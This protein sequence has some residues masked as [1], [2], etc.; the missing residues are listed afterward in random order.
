[1]LECVHSN[2]NKYHGFHYKE[3]LASKKRTARI[4]YRRTVYWSVSAQSNSTCRTKCCTHQPYRGFS[5]TRS[6]E[7]IFSH[8]H[9]HTLTHTSRPQSV[10]KRKNQNC[11]TKRKGIF[12]I[13]RQKIDLCPAPR[14]PPRQLAVTIILQGKKVDFLRPIPLYV[15]IV[16]VVK[17]WIMRSNARSTLSTAK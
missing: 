6:R 4:S 7:R 15:L 10:V 8:A 16:V 2:W 12:L 11:I 9:T 3:R 1:M 14:C 13:W 17:T 5:L